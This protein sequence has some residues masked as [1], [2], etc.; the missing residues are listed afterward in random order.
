M[1]TKRMAWTV[2]LAVLVFFVGLE[3][4]VGCAMLEPGPAGDSTRSQV[5]RFIRDYVPAPW[6][7][8]AATVVTTGAGAIAAARG[9]SATQAVGTARATMHGIEDIYRD[10]KERAD[11]ARAVGKVDA[12]AERIVATL[13]SVKETAARAA[14]VLGVE[15]VFESHVAEVSSWH[16][17]EPKDAE[18][19]VVA[20]V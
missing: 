6:G 4:G 12:D 10:A 15:Q 17:P 1:K 11:A 2:L 7:A 8:I 18:P 9:R 20:A 13:K 16:S 3:I 5:D 19:P 14:R